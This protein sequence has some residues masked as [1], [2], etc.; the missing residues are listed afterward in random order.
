[1]ARVDLDSLRSQL[2]GGDKRLTYRLTQA[3]QLQGDLQ[4]GQ[5]LIL[6]KFLAKTT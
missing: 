4:L 3:A 6:R 1:M 5:V 2:G